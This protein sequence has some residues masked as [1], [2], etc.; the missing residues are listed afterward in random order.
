MGRWLVTAGPF[1]PHVL[2]SNEPE[3]TDKQTKGQA[4]RPT[5][6]IA[7]IPA[8]STTFAR[9]NTHTLNV[10]PSPPPPPPRAPSPSRAAERPRRLRLRRRRPL[11]RPWRRWSACAA[12]SS[13][14]SSY[15]SSLQLAESSTSIMTETSCGWSAPPWAVWRPVT[16]SGRAGAPAGAPAGG[17]RASNG[18]FSM[19]V[20]LML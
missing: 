10:S 5:L 1:L 17:W 4:T 14:P 16:R 12:P 2:L 15:S 11:F 19:V 13:E 6:G 3:P 18:S 8:P 9:L 7:I 20:V